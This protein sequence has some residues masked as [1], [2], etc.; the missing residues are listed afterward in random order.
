MEADVRATEAG[1]SMAY[2]ERVPDFN[3]GLSAD[4]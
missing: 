2:K 3:A 1:I 4:V